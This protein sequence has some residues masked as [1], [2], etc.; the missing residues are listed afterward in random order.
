[1]QGGGGV[2][3]LDG[4]RIPPPLDAVRLPDL[5]RRCPSP[6]ALAPGLRG[7]MPGRADLSAALSAVIDT[8]GVDGLL[9]PLGLPFAVMGQ[10]D[11]EAM[12][13]AMVS[14][15]HPPPSA[16]DAFA[17]L[18]EDGG[19]DALDILWNPKGRDRAGWASSDSRRRRF[20]P[21]QPSPTYG[22]R[23]LLASLAADR[24]G[25]RSSGR[26]GGAILISPTEIAEW[27][28]VWEAGMWGCI[29]LRRDTMHPRTGFCESTDDLRALA[30]G[31]PIWPPFA[32]VPAWLPSW[33]EEAAALS[34]W[35][36]G[37]AFR[38]LP[39]PPPDLGRR[40]EEVDW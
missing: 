40:D 25:W 11:P 38:L 15:P 27:R 39:R 19:A 3:V 7:R 36:G 4:L 23:S 21:P 6:H 16:A 33:D 37:E 2:T 14:P 17:A 22:R 18:C 5:I 29:V 28:G 20:S 9:A 26:A 30:E 12:A 31:V 32:R 13:D 8:L 1:M 35:A 10:A 34:A 24:R